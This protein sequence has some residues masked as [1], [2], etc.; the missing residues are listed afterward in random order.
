MARGWHVFSRRG[1]FLAISFG[2]RRE[3]GPLG[4]MRKSAEVG[5]T[6]SNGRPVNRKR[7]RWPRFAFSG[8]E[9]C[10]ARVR[11]ISLNDLAASMSH[12]TYTECAIRTRTFSRE[13]IR[14]RLDPIRSPV[15]PY[16]IIRYD[17]IRYETTRY[18]TRYYRGA[19]HGAAR[20]KRCAYRIRAVAI[21]TRAA[22][23]NA[24]TTTT[25]ISCNEPDA[26]SKQIRTLSVTW[27]K[28]NVRFEWKRRYR[29]A[30]VLFGFVLVPWRCNEQREQSS[31]HRRSP[32]SYVAG[33]ISP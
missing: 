31:R 14:V 18:D 33:E 2:G 25:A 7:T 23:D 24:S 1:F 22:T 11:A 30:T 16:D 26:R 17:A 12:V 21:D 13:L 4:E 19:D 15:T 32:A 20:A 27:R 28:T 6:L 9:R 29:G 5:R 3:E 10:L 8:R